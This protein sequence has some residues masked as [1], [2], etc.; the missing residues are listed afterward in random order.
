MSRRWIFIG[1]LL[2]VSIAT[3][4]IIYWR[5]LAPELPRAEARPLDEVV[6]QGALLYV[7]ARDFSGLLKAWNSSPEKAAWIGSNSKSVFSQSRLFLRLQRF[8]NHFAA[9][10]GLPPD[11]EFVT[12]VAG[13]E[14]ALA[15][16]DVGKIQ[17]VYVTRLP[18]RDFLNSA[19]W[20]SR[21]K[22]PTR[23]AGGVTFFLGAD[24]PSKQAVAFAVAGDYFVLATREDLMVQTLELLDKKPVRSL[25]QERWYVAAVASAAKER[26]DLRMVLDMKRIAIE[27]HFRTYW[28]QQNITEMQ[29]YS[30]VVSDLYRQ[31]KI[32]REE[33]VLLR[34]SRGDA[35]TEASEDR[36]QAVVNLLRL[37]PAE[38]GFYQARP[39][40][41]DEALEALQQIIAPQTQQA[42]ETQRQAPQ[43]VLT[44]G[45]V[46]SE[47]DFETRIDAAIRNESEANHGSPE[48]KKQLELT[49]P[50]AVLEIQG[51][52]SSSDNP[53]I[54]MSHLLIV[55]AA[56]PWDM[57]AIRQAMQSQL[58]RALTVSELGVQWSAVNNS[59]DEFEL[60]GLHPLYVAVRGK[61]LY[62]GNDREILTKALNSSGLSHPV[63]GTTYDA[64]FNHAR[65]RLNFFELS[66]ILD[67]AS[68][69]ARW[70]G[71][72]PPRFFS[73]TIESLSDTLDAL[74]SE[75]VTEH[76]END[77]VFQTVTYTWS[78]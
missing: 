18:S 68:E 17:F 38:Y 15:L 74:E 19:L 72:N 33:R 52:R 21:N 55:N 69:P 50:M 9:A 66:R 45:E 36:S 5:S 43:L 2:A 16:Y 23:F 10:A 4:E 62:V 29:G 42:A 73:Q 46:G 22:F 70:D 27:P 11:T 41:S 31:G 78:R 71:S 13:E 35:G 57:S 20:Q 58:A 76:E 53:M 24:E 1:L 54:S 32:Y 67:L 14:S 7:E 49:G 47:S 8:L 51:T 12:A 75:R 59:Q 63:E 56:Q 40:G 37:I 48:L 3:A 26:G 64:G 44:G 77:K 34:K 39:A 6:P 28:I 25:S 60:N 61:L 30:A 65:E